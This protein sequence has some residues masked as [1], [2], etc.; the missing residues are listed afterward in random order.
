MINREST[1]KILK[2]SIVILGSIVIFG[3]A[4]F[5]SYDFIKGPEITIF[6]PL[7]GSS[8]ATS[9]VLIQGKASRIKDLYINSKPVQIDREGN[10]SE[11]ILL[12]HGYNI[13]LLSAQDRFRRTI[14]YK[15]ELVYLK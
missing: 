6:R 4:I 8:V 11:Y 15:L 9:T 3:Y 12:A 10:F 13:S 7:N 5:E 2:L 14:E 1:K